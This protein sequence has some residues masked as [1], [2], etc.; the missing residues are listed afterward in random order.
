MKKM[1]GTALKISA[2]FAAAVW[3]SGCEWFPGPEPGG[4]EPDLRALMANLRQPESLE[5]GAARAMEDTETGEPEESTESALLNGAPV[6]YRITT[7][8]FQASAAY[9][10]QVL[11]NP[12]TDVIYPGSV[13]LGHTIE[14]GSYLEL[15]KGR[16]RAVT[17]SFDLAG[18]TGTGGVPGIVSGT[19]V[20]SLSSYRELRN[21]ILSQTIPRQSSIYSFEMIEID[22]E[23]ELDLKLKAAVTYAGPAYEVQIKGGFDFSQSNTKKKT[24]V[25][26]MQTFYTVDVDQ[27][28]DLFLYEEIDLES[29]GGYR[30]VY[31]SSAAYGR[32]AYL[33]I[34]SEEDSTSIKSNLEVLFEGPTV[35][36]EAAFDQASEFFRT[37]T[38]T[39]ITVIG[40]TEVAIGLESFLEMLRDDSF[41]ETNAGKIVA[42]KLRF[43]DDN[44]IANTVFNGEY[45]VRSTETVIGGGI[46]VALQVTSVLA[47]VNDGD[48]TAE[49]FGTVSY[50]KD[51]AVKY[52]WSRPSSGYLTCTIN[53]DTPSPGEVQTFNFGSES[54]AFTVSITGFKEVDTF[55]DDEFDITVNGYTVADLTD[56]QPFKSRTYCSG[57][58]GEWV[59][60]TI[61]PTVTYHY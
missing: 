12:S 15:T 57:Y 50:T 14:D 34:E 3:L 36:G 44:T 10:T 13:I 8:R 25:R 49:L 55:D 27:G 41:S 35:S 21:T 43:V 54:G 58:P 32:L 4:E 33:S 22:D 18:V 56:G 38:Q 59:E 61:V 48:S 20:P 7:R 28:G 30:P 53:A 47:C 16:K 24:L 52:L 45:T 37:R 19:I 2:V 17:M 26:F 9:D 31:V 1:W 11:L 42:Y 46:D 5:T 29:F 39:N 51:G 6:T 60:F 40:G 23:T